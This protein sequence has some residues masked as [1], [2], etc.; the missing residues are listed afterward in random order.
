MLKSQ[1]LAKLRGILC[2][3]ET[4]FYC[5]ASSP[6]VVSPWLG[7]VALIYV[8]NLNEVCCANLDKDCRLSPHLQR[9]L[10]SIDAT[11]YS[12]IILLGPSSELGLFFCQMLKP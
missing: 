5:T 10:S 12:R 6:L 8:A 1:L 11:G 9:S 4:G 7:G 2:L 3:E